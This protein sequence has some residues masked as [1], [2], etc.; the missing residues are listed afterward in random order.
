MQATRDWLTESGSNYHLGNLSCGGMVQLRH[1]AARTI[2]VGEGP[3]LVLVPG[4]AGGIDLLGPL[5]RV[6]SQRFRVIAYQLRGEDDCF[7]LRRRFGFNDLVNDL[8]ELLDVLALE[9]PLVAGVSFGGMLALSLAAKDPTRVGHLAVQG[10]GA[11]FDP[12]TLIQLVQQVLAHYPL[13]PDSPFFNQFF[14][15]FFGGRMKAGPLLQF[16]TR[17]C[18]QTD[19][20]V[21]AHRF[22][23]VKTFDLGEKLARIQAP[24]LVLNGD[25]DQLVSKPSL[26]DLIQG[27]Q[28][29]KQVDLVGCG[30][31]AFV[32]HPQW[33]ADEIEAFASE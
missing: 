27:L 31:L 32:T 13:P 26:R 21:I 6:L 18:W 17:Q 25:R 7:A 3:P 10:V 9:A 11:R 14:N 5:V 15:L 24:T 20:S 12:G 22:E 4:L 16:V 8:R 1:Y 19:Q 28:N 29:G 30:H 33:L 23:M 2:E